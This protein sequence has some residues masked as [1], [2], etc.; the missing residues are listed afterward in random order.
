MTPEK[1]VFKI[2]TELLR[3][4]QHIG[5]ALRNQRIG[6]IYPSDSY[7]LNRT[8]TPSIGEAEDAFKNWNCAIL[9]AFR[10]SKDLPPEE[11]F[12]RNEN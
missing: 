2:Y 7:E 11:N 4:I 1:T 9:T 10:G 5:I 3:R 8:D 12:K 6:A